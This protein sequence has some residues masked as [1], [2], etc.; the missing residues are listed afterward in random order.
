MTTPVVTAAAAPPDDFGDEALDVG[1]VSRVDQ[2]ASRP[3]D[4]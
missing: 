1:I 2:T 4:P 3:R